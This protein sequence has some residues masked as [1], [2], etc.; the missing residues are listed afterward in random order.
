MC[1]KKYLTDVSRCLNVRESAR[2]LV[3]TQRLHNYSTKLT[4]SEM[5]DRLAK[6]ARRQT[7]GSKVD[8]EDALQSALTKLL[9]K[10]DI[11]KFHGDE[12][13]FIR[14]ASI[15]AKHYIIDLVR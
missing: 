10:L 3:D 15:V 14:W 11:G 1:P 4:S 9:E 5:T 7:Q 12:S 2:Q 8:W 13:D 6:I